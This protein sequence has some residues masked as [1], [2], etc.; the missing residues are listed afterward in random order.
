MREIKFRAW[1]GEKMRHDIAVIG[2]MAAVEENPD[3]DSYHGTIVTK[4][5]NI[6]LY[7]DWAKY[8]V[9]SWSLMQYTGLKDKNGVEI[10]ESD[11]IKIDDPEDKSTAE[12]VFA[13]GAFR[14]KYK[15]WDQSLPYPVIDDF[16]LKWFYVIGNVCQNPELLEK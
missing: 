1:D 15:G 13:D 12:I 5:G 2:G 16:D 14:K 10:W 3:G 7:S 8:K 9:K 6:D 4:S 11:I